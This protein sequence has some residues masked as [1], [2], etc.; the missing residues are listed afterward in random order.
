[1]RQALEYYFVNGDQL[2]T[3]LTV[4]LVCNGRK[5]FILYVRLIKYYTFFLNVFNVKSLLM[6][7]QRGCFG[8]AASAIGI[9]NCFKM[10]G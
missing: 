4:A 9:K 3:S 1:M 6:F 2:D 7:I 8:S 10:F 5:Y